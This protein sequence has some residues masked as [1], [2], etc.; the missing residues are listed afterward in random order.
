MDR[1]YGISRG[2]HPD[3][4]VRGR[5]TKVL[6]ELVADEY[7]REGGEGFVGI[8]MLEQG[9][10]VPGDALERQGIRVTQVVP[11]TPADKAGIVMGD[12]IVGM[13]ELVW[14]DVGAVFEFSNEIKRQKPGTQVILKVL[15]ND[16]VEE[17]PVLLARRPPG[18]DPR[19]LM[20]T[21][22]EL[23]E[24]DRA[25]KERFFRQWMD[26]RNEGE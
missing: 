13:G 19:L 22:E 26:R 25:A 23:M 5:C 4:E 10:A 1:L 12:L 6:R 2:G 20:L 16:Q 17:V 8:T 15:R 24:A 14:R 18:M 9:V 3:P 11:G 7:L 21:P